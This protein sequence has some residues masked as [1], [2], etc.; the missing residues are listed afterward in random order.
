MKNHSLIVTCL[1]FFFLSANLHAATISMSTRGINQGV[2]NSDFIGTWDRQTSSITTASLND[3]VSFYSGRNS[4]S[5]LSV[6]FST[7][8]DSEWGFQ[9]GLDAHY[10]AVFYIDGHLIGN[11]T[12]DLWWNR[13]WN[14]GDVMTLLGNDLVSGAHI[15]DIYWGESCCNGASSI[16]FTA[17]G[18]SWEAL[19]VENLNATAS[20]A[21][22]AVPEPL[23][24]WLFAIGL[25]GLMRQRVKN[26]AANDYKLSGRMILA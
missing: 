23:T 11:R 17:D 8:N 7:G 5:Y 18:A 1:L 9:L 15:L 16:R 24:V 13:N 25:L 21:A 3:F 14:H 20:V 6:D 10:G 26:K 2:D 19:S 12:D 22:A 4:L